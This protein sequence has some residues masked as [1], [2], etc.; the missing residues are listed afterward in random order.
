MQLEELAGDLA[1]AVS[2]SLSPPELVVEN[3]GDDWAPGDHRFS[4]CLASLCINSLNC[5][6]FMRQP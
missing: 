2:S 3:G 1:E 4:N 6:H 5:F